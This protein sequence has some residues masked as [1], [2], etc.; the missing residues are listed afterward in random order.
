[1]VSEDIMKEILY[2][3]VYFL[4]NAAVCFVSLLCASRIL[5]AP[6]KMWRC[7]V[8]AVYGG[9]VSC[10]A[11][12]LAPPVPAALLLGIAAPLPAVF[13]CFGGGSGKRFFLLCLFTLV[14]GIALGGLCEVVFYY[15]AFFGEGERV[16][17]GVF[18]FLL[19]FALGAWTMWGRV[20]RKRL[21]TAVVSMSVSLG[22]KRVDLYALVDS[23]LFLQDPVSGRSVVL[24]K[25]ACLEELL[26][27]SDLLSLR[28]GLVPRG[29]VNVPM[30]TA[31]GEGSLA[32]FC[33]DEA[34]L[35]SARYRKKH[36]KISVL[37]AVDLTPGAFAGCSGL[38]PLSV[39]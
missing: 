39:L 28:A 19:F 25:A 18:L 1:M 24:V 37:I 7:T 17:L 11:L 22:E 8:A 32:A 16:S 31:A 36:K 3:D 13:F 12:L 30:T 5:S 15:A 10:L 23:G 14:T 27:A 26:S 21:D 4:L 29:M 6:C 34:V 20:L 35:F 33:P 2:L 38:V 9:G